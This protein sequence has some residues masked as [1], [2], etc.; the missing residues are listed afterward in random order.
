M[1]IPQWFRDGLES[2]SWNLLGNLLPIWVLLL[3]TIINNGFSGR[4]MYNS[5]HQPF[6]YL[7]LSG[8]YLTSTYYIVSKGKNK[9][10]VF[11]FIFTIL[12]LVIGF[13]IPEK[14]SLENL[15]ANFTKE[16]A[17]IIV[18]STTISLYIYNQFRFYYL[19]YKID[20][21]AE[22]EKQIDDLEQNFDNL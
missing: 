1:K 15:S 4:E 12:L 21:Q 11:P 8:T 7:V 5:I 9:N 3:I 19:K 17:V 2:I 18:F 22:R 16:F 14:A 10:K 20:P 6:T 13:L